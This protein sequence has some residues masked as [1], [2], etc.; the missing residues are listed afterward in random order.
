MLVVAH[1][2][3][4]GLHR[5]SFLRVISPLNTLAANLR[6]GVLEHWVSVPI[7]RPIG[8]GRMAHAHVGNHPEQLS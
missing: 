8:W 4:A 5:H 2:K 3:R 6:A 1:L 7:P